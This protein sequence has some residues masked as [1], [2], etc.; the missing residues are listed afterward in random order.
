MTDEEV[1]LAEIPVVMVQLTRIARE[2]QDKSFLTEIFLS[3]VGSCF[4][5]GVMRWGKRY[6]F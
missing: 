5:R 6:A 4:R 1:I 3:M 2:V